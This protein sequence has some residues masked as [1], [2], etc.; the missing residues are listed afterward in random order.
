MLPAI[1]SQMGPESL[2]HVKRF[3]YTGQQRFGQMGGLSAAT[4]QDA[5]EQGDAEDSDDEDVPDLVSNFDEPSKAEL[6]VAAAAAAAAAAA[7]TAEGS[8][9]AEPS[10]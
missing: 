6:N 7:E 10:P 8:T 4:K 9:K 1:L 3:A 5:G 2:E